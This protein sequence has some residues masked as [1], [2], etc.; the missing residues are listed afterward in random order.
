MKT[1][2]PT[3]LRANIYK[4]LEDVLKTGVPLEVKKGK[5]RLRIVPAEPVDRLQNLVARP[6]VVHGDPDEL[7]DI[8]WE[9]EVELDLP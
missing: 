8:S 1:V 9:G 5:K 4:L 6:E 3:E 2:T 7:V